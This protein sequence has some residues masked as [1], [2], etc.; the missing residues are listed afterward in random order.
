MTTNPYRLP[1]TVIP[2][3][4]R[5]HLAPDLETFTFE[6]TTEIDIE[7][8]EPIGSIT[9]NAAELD[10]KATELTGPAGIHI[11]EVSFDEEYER[12][13][14][15]LSDT[16]EPGKYTLVVE[17]TGV[18]NDQLRG[19]YRSKFTDR[20]GVE[21]VIATSQCQATDARRVFPC[22]DEPD[23]KAT[24]KTT[25]VAPA[26]LEAYSN[27][28]EIGRTELEDGRVAVEFD[29]TI[30][31]STYLL[32]FVVGP[33]E[34]TEPVMA[35]GIPTRI[36]V[37]RGNL[38]L[39]DYALEAAV[40]SL[41]FLQDYYGIPYPGDKLDHIAIPDFSAG[42]MENV[43]L[44]TYRDAYLIIDP[45]K[46]TQAELER[47]LEVIGH[48]IAHQWFGNLVTL[49]WW[50]G[51]WLNEAFATFMEDKVVDAR[52]PDW[53]RYLSDHASGDKKWAHGTDHLA[54]TRPIEFEVQSPTEVDEMFDS[55]TYGKGAAV[56]RQL[57]Q[58]IGEEAFRNGVGGYLR[59]HAFSNTATTDLW[60]A[61]DNATDWPAA[62]IMNT[63]V[64]QRGLPQVDVSI[65]PGGIKLHQRRFLIIPDETDDTL[66]QIPV[67]VRGVADGRPF[68]KRALFTG[69]EM[70]VP[71]E[72]DV[73]YALVNAGGHGFY[74]V[75]YSED[76]AARLVANLADLEPIERFM[77]VDDARA[78]ME[79][80]QL[81]A[82]SYLDLVAGFGGES[83][84]AV[85]VEILGG[86]GA[87]EHHAL[88]PEAEP[89]FRVFVRELITP[90][91]DR[92]GLVAKQD[93]SDLDAKLRGS[94]I[95]AMGNLVQDPDMIEFARAV[96][97][98]L[99]GGK[100]VD[101]EI[102]TSS[103]GVLARHA[104]RADFDRLWKAYQD[105]ETSAEETRFLRAIGRANVEDAA[106]LIVDRI[107]GGEIRTQNINLMVILMLMTDLGDHAWQV[108]RRRWPEL[109]EAIPPFTR[110]WVISSLPA[111]SKPETAAD[112][113]AFFAET[114]FPEATLYLQQRLELLD[115]NVALRERETPVVTGYFAA[116]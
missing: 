8:V 52:R 80:G 42:A 85:W 91:L 97:D 88:A 19:W 82:S 54:S 90:A 40:W 60:E 58:F 43:G 17:Y 70:L 74:R 107:V 12:A 30:K 98:D 14:L 13:T 113:K 31:M 5:L 111:L 55:I 57:E 29:E 100:P 86:L 3:A 96:V 56:L 94:L 77:I 6:G 46:A 11:T 48:E 112:V 21:H 38:H 114:G 34:A 37:P 33:F 4:Y 23:F 35:K 75:R 2:T 59:K 47:S 44:I 116:G 32:A 89:E 87:V 101:N 9:L 99:I 83:E 20:E 84:W 51:A 1:R 79:S 25:I 39:T 69:D 50:E 110:R 68:E 7:I 67:I 81:P 64:Y 109:M 63:W 103:L 27:A 61:L 72:G 78:L 18:I 49:R 66:W 62:D 73:G 104:T 95:G 41:E 16:A 92:L 28:A 22:W 76:L 105:A 45:K 26:E 65:E 15:H 102:A 10:F 106:D 115:A 24:F 93:E 71:I 36:I 53:N 108:V